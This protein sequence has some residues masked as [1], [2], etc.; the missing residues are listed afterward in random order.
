MQC[1]NN[2]EKCGKSLQIIMWLSGSIV[3]V[4]EIKP[5]AAA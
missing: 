1:K 2:F 3:F 5:E 4:N